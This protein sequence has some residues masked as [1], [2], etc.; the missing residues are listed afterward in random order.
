MRIEFGK[1]KFDGVYEVATVG[2]YVDE[3]GYL[4]RTFDSTLFEEQGIDI[5]WV[6]QSLSYTT[7]KQTVRGLH[8]QRTPFKEIKLITIVTGRM[9][10]V[11]T[12]LRK[13]S[14]T[15]GQ[16][17]AVVLE[18]DKTNGLFVDGGFAHGCVSL[19]DDCYL[20]LNTDNYFSAEHGI[21]ILW[22]DPDLNIDWP[23]QT[24]SP[25]GAGIHTD[26]I[27]FKEFKDTYGGL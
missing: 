6:Q 13:N 5:T 8:T 10:W 25:D 17:Q 9:F 1:T 3:R 23:L 11:V 14:P 2:S 22:D 21:G 20:V 18:P 15:F 24:D 16:W 19:T 26:Y 27:T 7:K 12:D 4:A